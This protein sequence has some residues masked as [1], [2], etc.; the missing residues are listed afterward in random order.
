M[1]LVVQG[2]IDSFL[3]VF[4][5]S[6]AFLELMDAVRILFIDNA[7]VSEVQCGSFLNKTGVDERSKQG[8]ESPLSQR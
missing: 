8:E 5:L 6:K 1:L 2:F 3:N 4:A 7:G